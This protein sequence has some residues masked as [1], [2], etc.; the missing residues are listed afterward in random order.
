MDYILGV[1]RQSLKPEHL[2]VCS[3]VF[4]CAHKPESVGARHLV[5]KA[6]HEYEA[7]VQRRGTTFKPNA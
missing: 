6:V 7:L 4:S 5:L 2:N 3:Q 1:V